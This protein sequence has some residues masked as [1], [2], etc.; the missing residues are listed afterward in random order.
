MLTTRLPDVCQPGTNLEVQGNTK[1]ILPQACR[2]AVATVLD[3]LGRDT[4]KA[5]F[6]PDMTDMDVLH[7]VH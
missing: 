3:N 4:V 6:L 1:N 2:P 5:T 7:L